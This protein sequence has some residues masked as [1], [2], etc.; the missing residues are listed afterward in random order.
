M[1]IKEIL[2]LLLFFGIYF[3]CYS[4]LND[5]F[6]RIG[7][8][9]SNII[10]ISAINNYRGPDYSGLQYKNFNREK[11]AIFDDFNFS[12]GEKLINII[13]YATDELSN[14]RSPGMYVDFRNYWIVEYNS[15]KYLIEVE[16]GRQTSTQEDR[17][18]RKKNQKDGNGEITYVWEIQGQLVLEKMY[19]SLQLILPQLI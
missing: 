3:D 14:S 9:D 1:K 8:S 12:V 7:N 10:S 13:T 15:K 17:D 4:V 11:S 18:K 6:I 5:S 2:T 16:P 19:L